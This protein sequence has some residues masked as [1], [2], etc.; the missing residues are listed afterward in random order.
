MLRDGRTNKQTAVKEP[1][2]QI[3]RRCYDLFATIRPIFK[4]W[5]KGEE[6]KTLVHI[7]RK[8][9]GIHTF[10]VVESLGTQQF[11][12]WANSPQFWNRDVPY[13]IHQSSQL[14]TCSERDKSNSS[15]HICPQVFKIIFPL[16]VFS[17]KYCTLGCLFAGLQARSPYVFGTSCD[18]LSQH[19]FWNKIREG[20]K[21]PCR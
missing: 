2:D 20:S 10:Y 6:E 8:W 9:Y 1:E 18:R 19:R 3:W 12:I 15:L 14:N 4:K 5:R 11:R 16:E 13:R 17:P 7:L 21:V